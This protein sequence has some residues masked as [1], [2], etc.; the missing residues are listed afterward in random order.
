MIGAQMKLL[1]NGWSRVAKVGPQSLSLV[2]AHRIGE[3]GTG[4]P[5]HE[6]AALTT[7]TEIEQLVRAVTRSHSVAIHAKG[8]KPLDVWQGRMVPRQSKHDRTRAGECKRVQ[9]VVQR[10]PQMCVGRLRFDRRII[11]LNLNWSLETNRK[12]G[13]RAGYTGHPRA[14]PIGERADDPAFELIAG[15]RQEPRLDCQL[16]DLAG[17]SFQIASRRASSNPIHLSISSPVRPQ[18]KHHPMARS[19]VHTPTHGECWCAG[20]MSL[21]GRICMQRSLNHARRSS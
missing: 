21:L 4:C 13:H 2:P 1:E 12:L 11:H 5:K 17:S 10:Q 14:L 9:L 6:P 7:E 18:P 8:R 19:S 3:C 15:P 16:I 20:L